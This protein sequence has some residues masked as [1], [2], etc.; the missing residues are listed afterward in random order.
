MDRLG[1]QVIRSMGKA[2]PRPKKIKVLSAVQ[3][4]C[5]SAKPKAVPMKGAVHGLATNVAS[6]PVINE[7]I[8]LFPSVVF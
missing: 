1:R 8:R 3:I 7:E 6:N 4:G 2:I 5:V